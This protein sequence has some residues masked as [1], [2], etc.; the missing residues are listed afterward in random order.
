MPAILR[1][2]C[3][4]CGLVTRVEGNAD[5]RACMCGA[6]YAAEREE[7][8]GSLTPLEPSND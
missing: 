1:Y 5:H 7:E 2:T 6:P 8:D 3:T 4:A